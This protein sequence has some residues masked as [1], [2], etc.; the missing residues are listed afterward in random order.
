VILTL[1]NH[2]SQENQRLMAQYIVKHLDGL[3]KFYNL[4]SSYDY[5]FNFKEFLYKS[6][7]PN[8]K[9]LP[10]LS[11]LKRKIFIRVKLFNENFMAII[12]YI[13]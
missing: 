8:M 10:P 13:V 2:C 1:E 4:F 3:K 7:D 12:T 9:Q 5:F 6:F 11:S